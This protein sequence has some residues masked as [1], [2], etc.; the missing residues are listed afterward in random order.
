MEVNPTVRVAKTSELWTNSRVQL[1]VVAG[2]YLLA[3]GFSLTILEAVFWDDWVFLDDHTA[4]SNH[5]LQA[6]IPWASSF[7][8]F[9]GYEPLTYSLLTFVSF[10]S[11][12]LSFFG[13]LRRAPKF[14]Q[15]GQ[16]QILFA[17]VVFAI[18]PLNLAR[19]SGITVIYSLSTALFF[20]AWYLWV[21]TNKNSIGTVTL[22]VI[23]FCLSFFT[24]SLLAF[25]S[26]PFFHKLALEY[27]NVRPER[28]RAVIFR[29]SMYGSIP[30][31]WFA[32]YTLSKPEPFGFY[33]GYNSFALTLPLL[34]FSV[35][36]LFLTFSMIRIFHKLSETVG[37]TETSWR[38]AKGTPGQL[39]C[40][41]FLVTLAFFP[42]VA[43]GHL[44]PY[45]E[46]STRHEL[47]IA[48]GISVLAS[49]IFGLVNKIHLLLGS[50]F[51]AL[52]LLVSLSISMFLG[53]SAVADWSKQKVLLDYWSNSQAVSEAELVVIE[54]KSRTLNLFE[55]QYR[56]YEWS[57]QLRVS[58]GPNGPYALSDSESDF[59]A[60][61]S[62]FLREYSLLGSGPHP[63]SSKEYLLVTIR[64]TCG[65]PI[66]ALILGAALCLNIE[67][68]ERSFQDSR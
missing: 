41:L 19:L 4:I 54:D 13:I 12:S 47:L 31:A 18:A 63:S 28:R 42:Y 64:T 29:S 11:A 49:A 51:S 46:W 33:S 21:R 5:F 25:F 36:L 16:Q 62:G 38:R 66:E 15:L 30:F 32:V 10:L 9:F 23:L 68:K 65:G 50:L 8:L 39:L 57:G 52:V 1:G 6:G 58:T 22:V 37:A 67:E 56:F 14:L 17:S 24:N 48:A 26:A 43:V 27:S 3:W 59:E 2:S 53:I 61:Q 35:L 44:P 34:G 40:G 20:L 7:H 55:R 45:S 60:L